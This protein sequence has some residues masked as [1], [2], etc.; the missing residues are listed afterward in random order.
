[1][2]MPSSRAS[3][4]ISHCPVLTVRV[5]RRGSASA[6]WKGSAATKPATLP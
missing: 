2:L 5:S 6:G 3:L 1:M 4:A